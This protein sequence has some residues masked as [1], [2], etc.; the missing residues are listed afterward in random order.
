LTNDVQYDII[1]FLFLRGFLLF[2]CKNLPFRQHIYD[3]PDVSEEDYFN[4]MRYNLIYEFF[5]GRFF[6]VF[7]EKYYHKIID[8]S[9]LRSMFNDIHNGIRELKSQYPILHDVEFIVKDYDN[10]N[11]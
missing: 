9:T 10:L 4:N 6:T 2:F 11:I 5:N 7:T 8:Y 1:I 3:I